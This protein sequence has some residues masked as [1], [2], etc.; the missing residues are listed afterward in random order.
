MRQ[1][2][3]F[4]VFSNTFLLLLTSICLLVSSIFA[5]LMKVMKPSYDVS[6]MILWKEL[7]SNLIND[8]FMSR[9]ELKPYSSTSS[10]KESGPPID[11][12]NFIRRRRLFRTVS[13][14]YIDR[15]IQSEKELRQNCGLRR[16]KSEPCLRPTTAG[17]ALAQFGTA[18]GANEMNDFD[19]AGNGNGRGQ[20]G[21]TDSDSLGDGLSPLSGNTFAIGNGGLMTSG[22]YG[23]MHN[24]NS[25]R[26]ST[27]SL[28]T[29][30]GSCKF[31]SGGGNG[32][33]NGNN[34]GEAEC[35]Q[36]QVPLSVIS[37]IAQVANG[38]PDS[39]LMY[40]ILSYVSSLYTFSVK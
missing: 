37:K 34:F 7:Y 26:H 39:S 25:N 20:N 24:N 21:R 3:Y 15:Q 30:S 28:C 38:N 17:R 36:N 4:S 8:E 2:R 27:G 23:W 18:F 5:L 35:F 16:F 22:L 12:C 40:S 10:T 32:S 14:D 29:T 1:T 19:D 11:D 33:T 13:L 6:E 31:E 9:F